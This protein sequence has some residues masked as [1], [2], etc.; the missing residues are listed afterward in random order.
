MVA[1]FEHGN[2]SLGCA[3]DE[4]FLGYV[5]WKKKYASWT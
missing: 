1:S 5:F 2:E 4:T 3:E